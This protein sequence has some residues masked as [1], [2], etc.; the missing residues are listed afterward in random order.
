MSLTWIDTGTFD[1]LVAPTF[2]ELTPEKGFAVID[3]ET[4]GFKAGEDKIVEI[5]VVLLDV[6]YQPTHQIETLV[7][8]QRTMKASH[9]H[10]ISAK[11]V[12]N[13]PTFHDIALSL[14]SLLNGR[15]VVAHNVSFEKRFLVEEFKNSGF[16]KLN[17]L[18]PDNFLDTMVVAP[19]QFQGVGKSLGALTRASNIVIP[20]PHE[21]LPDAIGTAKLL[22]LTGPTDRFSDIPNHLLQADRRRYETKWQRRSINYGLNLWESRNRN[23]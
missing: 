7:N 16:F 21:A 2:D 10:K 22:G 23:I 3:L 5:G 4:T 13:S 11:E 18:H 15:T 17:F 9:V 14:F 8:P 12:A 1:G 19:R 6:N 20:E